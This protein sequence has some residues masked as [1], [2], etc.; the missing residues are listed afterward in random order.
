MFF[1]FIK[2]WQWQW[3][4]LEYGVRDRNAV[5]PRSHVLFYTA[6]MGQLTIWNGARFLINIHIDRNC[7]IKYKR[8]KIMAKM[9]RLGTYI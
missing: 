1:L 6:P 9:V 8:L 4:M 5:W 2:L 3:H 7:I